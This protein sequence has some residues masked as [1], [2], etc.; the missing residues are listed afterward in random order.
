MNYSG[1]S[2]LRNAL[3]GHRKWPRAWANREPRKHYDVL[4]I[5]AGGHGLAT[6]YYLAREHGMKVLLSGAG[7]DDIFTGYRRH[8]AYQREHLWSWLPGPARRLLARSVVDDDEDARAFVVT[9]V[10]RAGRHCD[11]RDRREHQHAG[12]FGH[13]KPIAVLIPGSGGLLGT[14]IV[15]AGQCPCRREAGNADAADSCFSAIV[16]MSMQ[17]LSLRPVPSGSSRETAPIVPLR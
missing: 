6:A 4:I 12:A 3:S 16:L 5:G 10:G 7:G 1:L 14:V 17:S 15:I 2:I 9:A 11:G 13:D 8:T